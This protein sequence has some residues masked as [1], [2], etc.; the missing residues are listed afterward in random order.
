VRV[1]LAGAAPLAN[2]VEEFLK[3]GMCAPM[4]QVGGRAG[5]GGL[6]GLGGLGGWGV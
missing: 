6:G 2:H 1:I 5:P 4:V 3:V